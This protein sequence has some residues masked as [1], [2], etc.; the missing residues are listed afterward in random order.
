MSFFCLFVQLLL[1]FESGMVVVWSLR[2]K[3]AEQRCMCSQV[4]RTVSVQASQLII[5]LSINHS[6]DQLKRQEI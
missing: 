5:S 6:L 4:R 1:G 2:G 3:T